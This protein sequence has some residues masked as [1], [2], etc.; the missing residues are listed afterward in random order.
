MYI[1]SDYFIEDPLERDYVL[2]IAYLCVATGA[3]SFTYFMEKL[4]IVRTRRI[5]TVLFGILFVIL[6]VIIVLSRF[7]PDLLQITQYFTYSFMIPM[8]GL[9]LFYMFKLNT[10]LPSKLKFYTYSLILFIFVFVIG[11]VGATDFAIEN[12]GIGIMMRVIGICLQ[13]IGVLIIASFFLRLPTWNELEWR[14]KLHS[15]IIVYAGGISMYQHDF[16]QK[17]KD[18]NPILLS[19]ALEMIS[20]L[21]K[22]VLPRSQLKVLDIQEKKILVQKGIYV[23][24]A[25]IADEKLDSLE[26]LLKTFLH[27]FEQF[28]GQYL[29]DWEGDTDIF[30]PT[31]AIVEKIFA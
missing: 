23:T 7:N 17:G 29:P 18:V 22:E 13:I 21:L 10:L 28:F 26:L 16:K 9:F 30:A 12:F 24:V 1:Y 31:K 4:A 2:Q 6:F 14:D 25:M 3:F 27:E 19:G 11:F 5:F 8:I 20:S 15:L